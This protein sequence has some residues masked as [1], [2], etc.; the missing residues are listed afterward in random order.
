MYNSSVSLKPCRSFVQLPWQ[1]VS[2]Q[3]PHFLEGFYL[4]FILRG[5]MF[6]IIIGSKDMI[7]QPHVLIPSLAVLKLMKL[8]PPFGYCVCISV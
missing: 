8:I 1:L 7:I 6:L 4:T 2:Y 3:C 5:T